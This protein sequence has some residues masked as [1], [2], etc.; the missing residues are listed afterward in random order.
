MGKS[1]L[2]KAKLKPITIIS[3]KWL[4]AILVI[5]IFGIS[6]PNFFAKKAY[7]ANYVQGFN[8]NKL[9]AFLRPGCFATNVGTYVGRGIVNGGVKIFN[10]ATGQKADPKGT[11]Y[12]G[13]TEP[14]NP[15]EASQG[16]QGN[17]GVNTGGNTGVSTPL[18]TNSAASGVNTC[19]RPDG[20]DTFGLV[21]LHKQA[22]DQA[23]DD[24]QDPIFSRLATITN[25]LFSAASVAMVFAAVWTGLIYIFSMGNEEQTKKAKKNF[26]YIII[27]LILLLGSF[28]IIKVVINVITASKLAG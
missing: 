15:N 27:G 5:A 6:Q 22:I 2:S 24:G 7:A 23:T 1:W 12:F 25:L 9:N 13:D 26:T 19:N 18:N 16:A 21:C 17:T 28:T 11:P 14:I 3:N 4:L 20:P 10:A 8:C